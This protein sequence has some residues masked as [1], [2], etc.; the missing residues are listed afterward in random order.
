MKILPGSPLAQIAAAS[1][2]TARTALMPST[3]S[4]ATH[5]ASPAREIR[6]TRHAATDALIYL[7]MAALVGGAYAISRTG[8]YDARSD[9][10]YWIGVVGAV[11]MLLLFAY[12]LRKR[13]ATMSRWGKA[14]HWFVVHMVLGVM[15]PVLVLAHSTFRIGSLNAGVALFSMLIVAAS[16]VVGRFIYLRVHQGL[17]GQLQTLESM[18]SEMGKTDG[19]VRGA[20]HFA[21]GAVQ[22]LQALQAHAGTQVDGWM[23]HLHRLVVLPWQLHREQRAIRREAIA[24]LRQVAK[25]QGWEP[26][27]LR[28]R[29]KRAARLVA[30]YVDAVLRAAQLAAYSKVFSLWHVLHVPFV[31]L[32]VLCAIAHVVAVHA[33]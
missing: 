24:A 5:A 12:P 30:Q 13:S 2:A 29:E 6:R 16:G 17:G 9:I 33:Y 27:T 11:M 18:Q 22:R 19:G 25:E 15:G 23:N 20:L 1:L 21:P 4:T 10:G 28:S 31:F 3:S 8:V 32:M 26:A 7:G 14:K